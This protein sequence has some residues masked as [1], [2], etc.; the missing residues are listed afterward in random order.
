MTEISGASGGSVLTLSVEEFERIRTLVYDRFG[1]HLAD[2]KRLLVQGRL[3]K[4]LRAQGY[5]S[6][7]DYA[8]DL[9]RSASSEQL[10]A[11]ADRISTNHS[12]F[13]REMDHFDYLLS[14][15]IPALEEEGHS[16]R[17]L[18]FWSAGASEGQ[19]PYS[20]AMA[21]HAHYGDK[22]F[23]AEPSILATDISVS[24]LE[25]ASRGV[26]PAGLLERVPQ[27]YRSYFS[28]LD[29]ERV[30]VEDGVK[31]AVLFKRLNLNQPAFP[32]RA[33]FHV[34]LCRNVMI[35]LDQEAKQALVSRFAEHLH[36]G[37]FLLVGHSE[38]LGRV[39]PGFR[40]LRQTVYQRWQ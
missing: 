22:A 5:T 9:E 30:R 24:A 7:A 4:E 10:L 20:L 29:Q 35:Y 25:L 13:F 8:D 6:F 33:R 36:P 31:R 18:R 14:D 32:F 15:L 39:V 12:F 28:R 40:Y 27:R 11:L 1:I 17:D 3:N 34:I 2:G 16:L 21:L 26:Y 37:G 38:S 23:G 19:E